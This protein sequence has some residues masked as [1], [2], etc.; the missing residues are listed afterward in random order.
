MKDQ[1]VQIETP[2]VLNKYAVMF[3]AVRRICA[4]A[5]AVAAAWAA[6]RGIVAE[7]AAFASIM[8]L[9]M[10]CFGVA[11]IHLHGETAHGKTGTAAKTAALMLIAGMLGACGGAAEAEDALPGFV[12]SKLEPALGREWARCVRPAD[13]MV[14][15]VMDSALSCGKP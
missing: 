13:G 9:L 7:Q 1:D 3:V 8:T 12:C 15:I 10:I 6:T 14:C 11:A 4:T 5:I 2:I